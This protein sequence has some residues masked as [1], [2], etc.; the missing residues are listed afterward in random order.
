[1]KGP[2]RR[3]QGVEHRFM[4]SITYCDSCNRPVLSEDLGGARHRPDG[5]S[6]CRVCWEAIPISRSG[7]AGSVGRWYERNG[8]IVAALVL[9]PPLGIL[10]AWTTQRTWS[11]RQRTLATALSVVVLVMPAASDAYN[12]RVRP[13]ETSPS[14]R[15]GGYDDPAEMARAQQLRKRWLQGPTPPGYSGLQI[16]LFVL[17][18][19]LPFIDWDPAEDFSL[20]DGSPIWTGTSSFGSLQVEARGH[21]GN[22]NFIQVISIDWAR[23][24]GRERI[25]AVNSGRIIAFIADVVGFSGAEVRSWFQDARKRVRREREPFERRMGP[26]L[27]KVSKLGVLDDGSMYITIMP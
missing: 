3:N 7:A 21:P 26:Y 5:K 6:F 4:V 12:N 22:L 15:Q 8:P 17:Q 24:A 2:S 9:C 19:D 13:P 10:L 25:D 14:V 16:S 1:M 18:R 23:D 27:V 11:V 20:K